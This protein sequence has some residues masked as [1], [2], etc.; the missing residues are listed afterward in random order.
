MALSVA[1]M[2]YSGHAFAQDNGGF[3]TET[4]NLLTGT[5]VKKSGIERTG[6]ITIKT[7]WSYPAI[8]P[9]YRYDFDML[10]GVVEGGKYSYMMGDIA[11]IT[12]LPPS[13]GPQ[14]LEVK[15]RNGAVVTLELISGHRTMFGNVGLN[16]ENVTVETDEFGRNII[17]S[18]EISRIIFESPAEYRRHSMSNLVDDLG[19]AID[20]GVRDDLIDEDLTIVLKKIQERMKERLKDGEKR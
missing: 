10:H 18:S 19:K 2:M 11:E 9:V 3:V 7:T 6:V 20:L 17:P 15:L 8:A 4:G 13:D 12:F 16:I 5:V 14:M 1:G